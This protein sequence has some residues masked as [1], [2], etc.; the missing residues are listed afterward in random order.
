MTIR[1]EYHPLQ[2]NLHPVYSLINVV[3]SPSALKCLLGLLE[4]WSRTEP[5]AILPADLDNATKAYVSESDD[6]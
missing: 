1:S 5:I 2:S 3:H 4:R 6:L